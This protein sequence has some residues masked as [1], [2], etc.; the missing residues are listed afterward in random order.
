MQYCDR[1]MCLVGSAVCPL[2][3]NEHLRKPE[4]ADYCLL[5]EEQTP[6][7]EHFA[8]LLADN[9]I[10]YTSLPVF[11]A[12]IVQRT[13]GQERYKFYVPYSQLEAARAVIQTAA[14]DE[15]QP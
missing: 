12:G 5:V 4:D 13:G 15:Q 10:P 11:G 1:C 7:A 6:W 9:D 8:Q 3:G 2:C 14:A